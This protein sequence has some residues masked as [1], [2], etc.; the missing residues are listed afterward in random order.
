MV[1][2]TAPP[3]IRDAAPPDLRDLD[4]E[5]LN[6]LYPTNMETMPDAIRQFRP[7]A[8]FAEL[9]MRFFEKA[10]REVVIFS[11]SFI[12]YRNERG[13]VSSIAPDFC[14]VFDVNLD[15][16]GDDRSYFVERAGKPPDLV[17]EIG[18]PSTA[19][20]DIEE[21]P[22]I[23]AHMGAGEY[24]LFD[25][26]DG[27]IYGFKLMGLRLVDGEYKPIELDERPD[28]TVRGY[29]EAL[30]LI[31]LWEDGYIRLIDPTTGRRLRR[32]IEIE[33][34]ERAAQ[35]RAETQRRRAEAAEAELAELRRR[36]SGQ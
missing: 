7:L 24:W 17:M 30:G 23:Y 18:S 15:D 6:K 34:S 32:P 2:T 25:P 27:D 14:V 33:A 35:R 26:E 5:T 21:K 19:E 1:T 22:A 29:S 13:G 3:P 4:V 11:D 10:G 28:G 9:L 8:L 36:I 20:R 12:Y 16:I 31:L